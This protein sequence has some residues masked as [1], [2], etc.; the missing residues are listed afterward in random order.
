[1]NQEL[2]HGFETELPALKQ[3]IATQSA[4]LETLPEPDRSPLTA[5]PLSNGPI[6]RGPSPIAKSP[7]SDKRGGLNGSLQ[8]LLEVLLEESTRLI[9]FAGVDSNKTEPC[10]GSD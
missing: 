6:V 3:S 4:E 5:P 10:L 7:H 1:M 2:F 8:H 9:S